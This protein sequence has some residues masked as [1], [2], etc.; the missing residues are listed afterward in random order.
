MSTKAA[1]ISNNDVISGKVSPDSNMFLAR[2]HDN[3]SPS[4]MR[5]DSFYD[6][7]EEIDNSVPGQRSIFR[8]AGFKMIDDGDS[9][10]DTQRKVEAEVEEI[11]V[12]SLLILIA[13]ISY[14]NIFFV[15]L[16]F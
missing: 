7:G 12:I 11:K 10:S 6:T 15:G 2:I 5:I 4:A 14:S 3:N 9:G 8:S 1:P 13:I 16:G